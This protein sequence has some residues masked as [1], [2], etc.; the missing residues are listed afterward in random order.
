VTSLVVNILESL[1]VLYLI[2]G[3]LASAVYGA[4]RTTMD[5]DLVAELR[6]EHVDLPVCALESAFYVDAGMVQEVIRNRSSFNMIHLE[7]I[8]KVD[9]F[10]HRERPFDRSQF[11]RRIPQSLSAEPE[12]RAYFASPEDT[13]LA[14]LDDVSDRRW[15]DVQA[16]LKAQR[17]QRELP[18]L[19]R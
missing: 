4:A 17:G 7:T 13:V 3:F 5:G 11:E 18:Y 9:V 14:K 10:I 2:G 1:N 19:R 6:V 12:H 16:V 8:F 15:R